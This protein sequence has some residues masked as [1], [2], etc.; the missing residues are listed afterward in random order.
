MTVAAVKAE[1]VAAPDK[2]PEVEALLGGIFERMEYP[3]RLEFKDMPDGGL[4]VAVHFD[5]E[6]PGIAPS[7]RSYLVDC[8]QFLVNKV[9]NRPNVEKRWVTLGV[10]AFPEPRPPK[11]EANP[12]P[13]PPRASVP[14]AVPAAAPPTN[15]AK[16]PQTPPAGAKAATPAH[17][18]RKHEADE[19][20]LN[21]EPTAVMTR[22]GT[23]L[24]EKAAKFGR[25]YAVTLLGPEDRARVLKAASA[26]KGQSVKVEGEGHFRRVTFSPEKPV[27]MAKKQVMPDFDDEAE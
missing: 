19:V 13:P 8:I 5:G 10:N 4:G 1:P 20:S 26:V 14:K 18:G 24:A 7:K 12:N 9:V 16:K 21:V 17:A 6:L 15:S 3:A 27:P 2:R 11:G 23:G 22:L 25:F